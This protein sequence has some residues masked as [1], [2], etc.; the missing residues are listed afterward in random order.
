MKHN[1]KRILPLAAL[2]FSLAC[3]NAAAQNEG[4]RLQC[5]NVVVERDEQKSI[6]IALV[7]DVDFTAF[8]CDITIPS[9]GKFVETD[10][11]IISG[12]SRLSKTHQIVE[13]RLADNK[14]RFIVYSAYNTPF[15]NDV[16]TLF[17]Y[18]ISAQNPGVESQ[19]ETTISNIVFSQVNN[20]GNEAEC[21][22]HKF[23]DLSISTS[24]T[25]IN[26]PATNSMKIFA[27]NMQIIILSPTNTTLQLTNT[28]G[29]T[30]TLT[31]KAGKNVFNVSEPGVYIVGKDKVIVK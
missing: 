1:I 7:N 4:N 23:S 31:V 12:S 5:D 18:A 11:K 19:G 29:I 22:E 27:E 28:A 26:A 3:S 2:A 6:N 14:L 17:S 24:F 8:Q 21:I 10:G 9:D 30:T 25:G 20:N 16:P 15:N 13:K